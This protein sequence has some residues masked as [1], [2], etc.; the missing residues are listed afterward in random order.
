MLMQVKSV[1]TA[2]DNSE[3]APV[4]TAPPVTPQASNPPKEKTFTQEEV[5]GII[6]ARL[7]KVEDKSK[8]EINELLTKLEKLEQSVTLSD[9]DRETLQSEIKALK[10]SKLSVEEQRAREVEE[11]QKALQSTTENLTKRE[12]EIRREY[13]DY[14]ITQEL[15]EAAIAN[16]AR[17]PE[18]LIR[19]LKSGTRIKPV[20][21]DQG[22]PTGQS[23]VLVEVEEKTKDGQII[24]VE[25]PPME[26]IKKLRLMSDV[27][28]N[29]FN[30]RS[31]PG[32]DEMSHGERYTPGDDKLPLKDFEAYKNSPAR[33]K[34]IVGK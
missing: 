16:D 9:T 13:E 34:F 20:L 24:H 5:N 23:Q 12:L 15:R 30:S 4:V 32:L 21:D 22:K 3:E 11:L 25:V 31:R 8:Q 6:Q 28:G 26:A 7:A 33:K 14:R 2:C 29:Q 27:W 18:Q 17:T 1:T 19:L 10:N